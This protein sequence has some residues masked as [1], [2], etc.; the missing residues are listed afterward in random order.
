M[1]TERPQWFDDW[2]NPPPFIRALNEVRQLSAR[3]GWSITMF[4]RSRLLLI[5]TPRL[6]SA[7]ASSF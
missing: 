3:E 1:V 4:R 6:R 7:I 5:N 2:D